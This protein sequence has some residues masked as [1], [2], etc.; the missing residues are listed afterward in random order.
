LFDQTGPEKAVRESWM[1]EIPDSLGS[2]LGMP[3][4]KTRFGDGKKTKIDRT[5]WTQT[6]QDK[7][8]KLQ[9]IL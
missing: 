3:V 5:G 9:V 6:P 4:A 2:A 8:R 7:E 1:T